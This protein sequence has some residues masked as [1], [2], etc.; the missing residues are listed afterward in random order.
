M[1]VDILQFSELCP[2]GEVSGQ[3]L[4]LLHITDGYQVQQGHGLVFLHLNFS[5]LH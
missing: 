5:Q 4:K 2:K 1:T 3:G